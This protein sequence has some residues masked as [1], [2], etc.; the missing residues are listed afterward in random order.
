MKRF[1]A[2]VCGTV[3]AACRRTEWRR[4]MKSACSSPVPPRCTQEQAA[5]PNRPVRAMFGGAYIELSCGRRHRH[6]TRSVAYSLPFPLYLFSLLDSESRG[7]LGATSKETHAADAVLLALAPFLC[8][9][10]SPATCRARTPPTHTHSRHITHE[11]Q[12]GPAHAQCRRQQG[13]REVRQGRSG[14]DFGE[15]PGL[16]EQS[17]AGLGWPR[18]ASIGLGRAGCANRGD[19]D[20]YNRPLAGLRARDPRLQGNFGT[21]RRQRRSQN[22][23]SD[24]HLAQS[25]GPSPKDPTEV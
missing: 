12:H 24:V 9:I 2:F 7:H 16:L 15:M 22:C 1:I 8:V 6:F 20:N 25:A 3:R 4:D 23:P 17:S 19:S 13:H 11:Q 18:L 10:S 5:H 21:R 14:Q